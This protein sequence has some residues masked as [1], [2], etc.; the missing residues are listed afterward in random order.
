MNFSV[1]YDNARGYRNDFKELYD[2]L[3]QLSREK[4]KDK[5]LVSWFRLRKRRINQILKPMQIEIKR[6]IKE[7]QK[8]ME[9]SF[10]VLDGLN[11]FKD[12]VGENKTAYN[13]EILNETLTEFLEN[14]AH[15]TKEKCKSVKKLNNL[16][17]QVKNY[18]SVSQ[19][20]IEYL[21]KVLLDIESA[22]KLF[23]SIKRTKEIDIDEFSMVI[24]VVNEINDDLGLQIL[25]I[26]ELPETSNEAIIKKLY[27]KIKTKI[28]EI[29]TRYDMKIF[30]KPKERLRIIS[31]DISNDRGMRAFNNRANEIKQLTNDSIT[32]FNMKYWQ[33]TGK[34]WEKVGT[35]K[36]GYRSVN[37]THDKIEKI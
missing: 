32:I 36:H 17:F 14:I 20:N 7:E 37:A 30:K 12:I 33:I 35:N 18:L 5:R 22:I 2:L 10:K 16:E 26:Q 15:I 9:L 13:E 6:R 8:K 28:S 34:R 24:R 19:N 27:E 1:V 29:D 11:Q 31:H 23:L 4:E 25:N 3:I 21:E